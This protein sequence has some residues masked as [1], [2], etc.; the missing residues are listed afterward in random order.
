M[1]PRQHI[2]TLPKE[3]S[4]PEEVLQTAGSELNRKKT[5]ERAII[6]SLCSRRASGYRPNAPSHPP[7]EFPRGPRFARGTYSRWQ[8]H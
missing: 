5:S 7:R 2:G 3:R 8:R 6:A 4:L 1:G